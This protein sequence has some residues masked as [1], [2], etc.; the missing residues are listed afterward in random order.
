MR[1]SSRFLWDAASATSVATMMSLGYFCIVPVILSLDE[2]TN[3]LSTPSRTQI[4]TI[5]DLLM[6]LPFATPQNHL[7][8]YLFGGNH[9]LLDLNLIDGRLS[10][11]GSRTPM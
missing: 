11:S 3:T 2:F 4:A 1:R 7:V 10:R 9:T 8:V 6:G 5:M